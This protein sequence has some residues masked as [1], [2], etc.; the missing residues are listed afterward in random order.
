MIQGFYFAYAE[1]YRHCGG[2][3][4]RVN[5]LCIRYKNALDHGRFAKRK[6]KWK[7]GIFLAGLPSRSSHEQQLRPRTGGVLRE[8]FHARVRVGVARESLYLFA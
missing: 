6:R 1:L 3:F 2:P 4:A 5:H 7:L 8:P